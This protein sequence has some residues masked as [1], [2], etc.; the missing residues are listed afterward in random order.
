MA[1]SAGR[2][3]EHLFRSRRVDRRERLVAELKALVAVNV[4]LMSPP[5]SACR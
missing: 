3:G 2:Y 4:L 1:C 5:S